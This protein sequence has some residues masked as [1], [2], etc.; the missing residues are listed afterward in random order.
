MILANAENII[1]NGKV[2]PD[3]YVNGVRV[4]PLNG[5]IEAFRVYLEFA[6]NQSDNMTFRGVGW[7]GNPGSLSESMILEASFKY[8]S[9]WYDMSSSDLANVLDTSSRGSIYCQGISLLIDATTLVNFQWR[10]QQYYAPTHDV[11]MTV[12]ANYTEGDT[13]LRAEK[14]VTQAAN[15]TFVIYD[16]EFDT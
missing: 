2:D 4:W 7:N 16:G 8:N 14:T 15:T 1:V 9:S 12:Y 11:K 5:T 13:R 3:I 10:T 6:D